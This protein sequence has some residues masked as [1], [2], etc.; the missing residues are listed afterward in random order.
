MSLN[1]RILSSVSRA[2]R[3][4][5]NLV[6]MAIASV[7][8][9]IGLLKFVPYEADSI[10]PMVA[11]SPFMS[12][13]YKHPEQYKQHM[14]QEGQLV[15]AA[16]VWQEE[17]NTYRFSKGLGT[18]ELA[19]AVLVLFNPLSRRA[20][21]IG[22]LLSFLT[23]VVTLSFLISTPEAWVS[24]LGDAQHGFPYLSGMG[25]LIWK[26]TIMMA[27]AVGV[28]AD[29]ARSILDERAVDMLLGRRSAP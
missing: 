16:R 24:A 26:D 23:P 5:V 2:D 4:G 1:Q 9:W 3:L 29:S 27:G 19:I 28:M 18:V 15:P 25:R 17:N 14:T 13:F 20:G 11:H 21:L 8:R 12:Y 6:R 22:G 10:T 7:C